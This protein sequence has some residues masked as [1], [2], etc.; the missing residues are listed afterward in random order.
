MAIK[1]IEFVDDFELIDENQIIEPTEQNDPAKQSQII[2]T[3]DE[4]PKVIEDADND[5]DDDE[6]SPISVNQATDS[7]EFNPLHEN[8]NFL[9]EQGLFV[10]PED[11]KYDGTEEGFQKAVEDSKSEMF[12]LVANELYDK[13]PDELRDVVKYV[14][15]GGD[16]IN[17]FINYNND[18]FKDVDIYDEDVRKDILKTY[19]KDKGLTDDKAEKQVTKSFDL[20]T[21]EEDASEALEELKQS[22]AINKQKLE[23]EAKLQKEQDKKAE[24]EA[25]AKLYKTLNESKEIYGVEITDADKKSF[26]EFTQT[27]YKTKDNK[28]VT[29]FDAKL[30]EHLTDP[31]KFILLTKFLQNG[32]NVKTKTNTNKTEKEVKKS[33]YDKIKNNS[34]R[35]DGKSKTRLG[36]QSSRSKY[37]I[38]DG[39]IEFELDN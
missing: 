33:F 8:F 4:E 37:S 21:D 26:K 39:T 23:A 12:N 7:D 18:P 24:Q 1:D 6:E 3:L 35:S 29:K 10:L 2:E 34:N 27:R 5:N 20:G 25:L 19:W 36:D 13:L 22:F 9:K 28:V 11:Y 15:D 17:G 38:T 31:E 14:L 16:D 30:E 32:Y